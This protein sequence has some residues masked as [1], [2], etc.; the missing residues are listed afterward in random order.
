LSGNEV[1]VGIDVSKASLEVATSESERIF[2]WRNASRG[3]RA[4]AAHLHQVRPAL[5]VTEASG[6]YERSIVS[7]LAAAGLNVAVVNPR[8]V[9]EFARATG[10]LAKTD[11][12]DA[13]ILC[14]FAAAIRPQ[15]RHLASAEEQ[16]FKDLQARRQQLVEM[17]TA[18]KN[19]LGM[20]GPQVAKE[21]RQ[22]LGWLEKRL[23]AVETELRRRIQANATWR[24]RDELLQSVP[25]VGPALATVLLADLPELGAANRR[26]IAA[27]VGVAPLNNDSGQHRGKRI[28]WGGRRNVRSVLYMATL[29]ASRSNPVIKPLYQR[30]VVAGK[31]KKVALVACMRKLLTIL[32]SMLREQT[33][34]DEMR[35]AT[36][37]SC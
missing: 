12:I 14:R 15:V 13:R 3:I 7:A 37:H 29:A 35:A 5:I 34:W 27:L 33:S 16:E 9:R 30:L 1:F 23:K 21:I 4:A 28:V 2:T 18:E 10:T 8:Q 32:N 24:V 19:R 22:H 36:Q 31:P 6:G 25:G 20:A 17:I 26:Q 11:A